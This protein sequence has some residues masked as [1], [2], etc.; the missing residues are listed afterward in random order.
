MVNRND[1]SKWIEL[2]EAQAL[3]IIGGDGEEG[4][5]YPKYPGPCTGPLPKEYPQWDRLWE[6][7]RTLPKP[8]PNPP[9][10]SSRPT[11]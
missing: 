7:V 3:V 1:L 6:I 10:P 9:F 5:Q 4:E 8:A 2:S 11:D